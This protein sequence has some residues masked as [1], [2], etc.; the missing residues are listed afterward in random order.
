MKNTLIPGGEWL[1]FKIYSGP[2]TADLILTQLVLPFVT[3]LRDDKIIDKWFFIRYLDAHMH[4][5]IRFH[6]P[7][8]KNINVVFQEFSQTVDEYFRAS[9]VWKVQIDTYFREIW[10]YGIKSMGQVETFFTI[11]SDFIVNLIRANMQVDYHNQWLYSILSIDRL[12]NDSNFELQEKFNL[13]AKMVEIYGNHHLR[14]KSVKAQIDKKYRCEM[15]LIE[16]IIT[17]KKEYAGEDNHCFN[18]IEEKSIKSKIVLN[19]I[20]NLTEDGSESIFFKDLIGD[21]IHL[22]INRMFTSR[23]RDIEF[24]LYYF[25]QNYYRSAIYRKN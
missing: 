21:I 11:D 19:Q 8:K 18:L 6:I 3:R 10:R 12:L 15:N 20:R 13:M 17:S 25:L 14:N 23:Q 7:D 1:Y 9:L 4:L 24:I 5:R 2:Q 22:S 16:K